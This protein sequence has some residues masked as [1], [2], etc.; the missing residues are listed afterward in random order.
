MDHPVPEPT[1][2]LPQHGDRIKPT[3][4]QRLVYFFSVI[5]TPVASSV[6]WL[7]SCGADH[8]DS[9]FT[10][11]IL[12]SIA[13]IILCWFFIRRKA[14]QEEFCIEAQYDNNCNCALAEIDTDFDAGNTTDFDA[15]NTT[16]IDG[17]NIAD[18]DGG[19]TADDEGGNTAD[20]EGGN[21]TDDEGGNTADDEGEMSSDENDSDDSDIQEYIRRLN[22]LTNDGVDEAMEDALNRLSERA[23]AALMD[24]FTDDSMEDVTDDSMEDFLDHLAAEG[25]P[26]KISGNIPS[27]RGRRNTV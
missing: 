14:P 21:T 4:K 12:L 3:L 23:V 17:G 22:L 16:D 27:S 19:N 7:I 1:H 18:I 8:I 9:R 25:L 11:I 15:G 5:P 20:D 24:D 2:S 26:Q 10:W 13:A 6:E